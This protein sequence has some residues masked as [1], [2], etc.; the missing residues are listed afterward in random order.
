MLIIWLGK[1]GFV[2][3]VVHERSYV[4][5]ITILIWFALELLQKKACFWLIMSS[6]S[7]VGVMEQSGGNILT[8]IRAFSVHLPLIPRLLYYCCYCGPPAVARVV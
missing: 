1:K 6:H 5:V 4:S 8:D 3:G 2:V 7:R